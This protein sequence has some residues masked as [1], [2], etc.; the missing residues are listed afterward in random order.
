MEPGFQQ[1]FFLVNLLR[2]RTLNPYVHQG[3][4]LMMF[5]PAGSAE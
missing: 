2:L 3:E 4:M 1:D 5:R